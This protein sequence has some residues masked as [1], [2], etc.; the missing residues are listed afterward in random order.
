MVRP[1]PL[2]AGLALGQRIDELRNVAGR[3]PHRAGEYD[4][5]VQADDIVAQ[6]DHRPPPLP[7]DVALQLHTERSVVPGRPAAAVDLTGRVD[8]TAALGQADDRVDAVCG[9]SFLL[10]AGWLS[11]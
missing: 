4:R 2:V 11:A 1:E 6:L 10:I 8:E 5:G 9:H 7:A 3:L